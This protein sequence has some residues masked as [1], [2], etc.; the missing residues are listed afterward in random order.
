M[1][2]ASIKELNHILGNIDIHLLDQVLKARFDEK[3]KILDAGCGDGRNLIYFVRHD[4]QVWGID[5]N[6]NSIEMLK[7]LVKS[8]ND[9][10]PLSRFIVAHAE[11]LPFQLNEFDAVI[12]SAVLHFAESKKHFFAML[13]EMIRVL[14]TGG[15]FF[16]RMTADLGMEDRIKP[17]SEGKFLLPDQSVRYL[18]TKQQLKEIMDTFRFEF[19]EPFKTVIVDDKRC[20][21]TLVLRKL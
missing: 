9:H 10:Y 5:K 2:R 6:P 17:L 19:I 7:H 21:S 13:K 15:I 14:K 8:V 11:D 16:C 12:S 1:L 20:M 3:F 18:L 4:Y